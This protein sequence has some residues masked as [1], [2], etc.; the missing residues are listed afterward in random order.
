[1]LAPDKGSRLNSGMAVWISIVKPFPMTMNSVFLS[2]CGG[3]L[4]RVGKRSDMARIL[5][6][7]P[8]HTGSSFLTSTRSLI[9]YTNS[10]YMY[11][12]RVAPDTEAEELQVG[13]SRN[14]TETRSDDVLIPTIFRWP[15]HIPCERVA[16]KGSFDDWRDEYPLRRCMSGGDWSCAIDLPQSIGKVHFK[17]V[18][19]GRYMTSP[20]EPIVNETSG[21]YNNMRLVYPNATFCWP[22]SLLGGQAI[23]VVGEWDNFEQ[24]LELTCQQASN[25]GVTNHRLQCCLPPGRYAYYYLVDGMIKLRP[26]T[27]ADMSYSSG[28][29][30]VNF[31]DVPQPPAV[32][33]YYATGWDEPRLKYRWIGPGGPL[34]DGWEIARMHKTAARCHGSGSNKSWKF[35]IIDCCSFM[36]TSNEPLE[37]EFIPF[38]SETMKEDTPYHGGQYRCGFPGGY[39]LESGI[40]RPFNQACDPPMLL[41]SDIDGTLVGHDP[42]TSSV[43][44]RFARYWEER[45]SLTGSFLVYNTG[46][47]LGQV[48]GLLEHMKGVLPVPDALITAVGTKI[49]LLDRENGHRGTTSGL[50]WHEDLDWARSLDEGWNLD[51]VRQVAAELV[52]SL[53]TERATWLDDGSEHPHRISLSVHVE[54]VPYVKETLHEKLSRHNLEFKIISSG[55]ME[56]RYIDCVSGHAGKHAALEHIRS[57]FGVAVNRTV[58][59]GD[60]GNDILMLEGK[61]PAI[62]VGN[63]QLELVEW[64]VRQPQDGRI[65]VADAHLSDGVLEGLCRHQLY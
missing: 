60:S 15:R 64:V 41:V 19:D 8:K 32:R 13:N 57:L 46:R 45:A 7:N 42:E 38:D 6:V 21:T 12:V 39:K 44:A 63:A 53:S 59:A 31:V 11:R 58:A 49:Y 54:C 48:T 43:T 20:S 27:Q 61:N 34:K 22:S 47:S 23:E 5:P 50:H 55:T 14:G 2:L 37:L 36:Q 28:G 65:V 51:I 29:R 24:S 17:F 52:E 56:W 16:L 1:M 4:S 26:G 62:V 10:N 33:L 3:G 35:A 30:A 25:F 9:R 18:V 40:I